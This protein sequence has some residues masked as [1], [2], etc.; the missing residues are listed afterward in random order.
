VQEGESASQVSE[1]LMEAGIVENPLLLRCY[2]R[3]SGMDMGIE[4]GRYELDG[5]MSI[6]EI[7]QVLQH[8]KATGVQLTVL[9]GWRLEEIAAHLP[10]EGLAFDGLD[11]YAASMMRPDGYSFSQQIP[12]PCSLE[13]FL[14]PDTYLLTP[15]TS[16]IELVIMM[17]DNFEQ[18]V[19]P[20]MQAGFNEQGLTLYQ[21]VILASI[22]ER[23]AVLDEERPQIASVFLNRLRIDMHLEA[24]P[25]VQYALGQQP[26]G[27]W[28]K[29][30]LTLADLQIA[31][32]FNTYV[33]SG[34]P[35]RPICNPG[36]SSLRAVAFPAQ[37]P[38]YFFVAACDGSGR[39]VFSE[40]YEEHLRN[41]CP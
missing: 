6:M 31:S 21:A 14:F 28:W 10:A 13:G 22:I 17:L 25:T 16:A 37:T 18:R 7:A 39:H 27:S 24:D 19:G 4:A 36:I 3:Y 5:D 38:Y 12:E 20:S 40:T 30:P 34:L 8:A 33:N 23:E 35:P 1:H 11:F 29:A 15:R 41:L 26:D 9:E 2:M 32:P